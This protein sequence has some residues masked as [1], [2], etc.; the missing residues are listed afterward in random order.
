MT[1]RVDPESK[2]GAGCELLGNLIA[3]FLGAGEM[4]AEI[5]EIEGLGRGEKKSRWRRVRAERSEKAAAWWWSVVRRI[6]VD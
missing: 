4:E 1:V 5:L 6:G 2:S 3:E